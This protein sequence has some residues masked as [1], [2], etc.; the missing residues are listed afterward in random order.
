VDVLKIGP[1]LFRLRAFRFR[2]VGARSPEIPG[3]VRSDQ[4]YHQHADPNQQKQVDKSSP[5]H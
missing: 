5:S 4:I 3:S 2:I 1:Q